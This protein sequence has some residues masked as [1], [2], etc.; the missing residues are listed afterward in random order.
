MCG[1]TRFIPKSK[2]RGGRTRTARGLFSKVT[3]QQGCAT[4]P[5]LDSTRRGLKRWNISPGRRSGSGL[6]H[7]VL[8]EASTMSSGGGERRGEYIRDEVQHA[9]VWR[10]IPTAGEGEEMWQPP[11][12]T[13][14]SRSPS[15]K[16]LM[17]AETV[18]ARRTPCCDTQSR[19]DGWS[20]FDPGGHMF[21]FMNSRDGYFYFAHVW[22]RR[23]NSHLFFQ[24]IYIL[25]EMEVRQEK[26]KIYWQCIL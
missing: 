25:W 18:A 15:D 20:V 26:K 22:R 8:G 13:S 21:N 24:V 16:V 9:G 14:D 23:K 10:P 17:E 6:H 4:H 2:R 11:D 12:G 3:E 7:I 19:R 1:F 5:G